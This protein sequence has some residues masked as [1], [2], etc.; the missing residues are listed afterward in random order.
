MKSLAYSSL[1]CLILKYGAVC[2]DLFR[3]GQT[4]CKRKRQNLEIFTNKSK[5]EMLAQRRK[6]ACICV[7][8]KAYSGEPPWMVKGNIT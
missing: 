6:V 5:W 8:Y 2:W 7:L 4:R 1:V 3:E